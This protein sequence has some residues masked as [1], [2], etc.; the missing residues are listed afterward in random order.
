MK[1]WRNIKDTYMKTLKKPKS[2]SGTNKGRQ[3]LYAKQLSFLQQSSL[4]TET[5]SSLHSEQLL[6]D[7]EN[8]ESRATSDIDHDQNNLPSIN[9]FSNKGKR[10]RDIETSLLA[11][12]NSPIRRIRRP[13]LS[14]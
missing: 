5:E 14:Y 3:Y 10:K 4:I 12:M 1:N 8:E 6:S 13:L 2:G 7:E 9:R 11:F